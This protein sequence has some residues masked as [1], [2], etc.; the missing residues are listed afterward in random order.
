MKDQLER[1]VAGQGSLYQVLGVPLNT[2]AKEID[3]AYRRI[4][5]TTHPDKTQSLPQ[6]EREAAESRFREATLARDVLKNQRSNYIAYQV[7]R[8]F[9]PNLPVFSQSSSLDRLLDKVDFFGVAKVVQ[10]R[11]EDNTNQEELKP[12]KKSEQEQ[13]KAY[14]VISDFANEWYTSQVNIVYQKHFQEKYKE[15][16]DKVFYVFPQI[17]KNETAYD[18]LKSLAKEAAKK[19]AE[20][21]IKP[22]KEKRTEVVSQL[23]DYI[24]RRVSIRI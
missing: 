21:K 4:A 12:R 17:R 7:V 14:Q 3:E 23:R 1:I 9:F 24:C 11:S 5:I 18:G 13:K 19:F 22:L 2:N 16:L 8:Y 6:C 10:R 15:I 20:K